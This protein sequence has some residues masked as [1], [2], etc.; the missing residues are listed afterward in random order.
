MDCSLTWYGASEM[1]VYWPP[2][3]LSFSRPL[4]SSQQKKMKPLKHSQSSPLDNHTHLTELDN[5]KSQPIP[6]RALTNIETARA[7]D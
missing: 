6:K 2:T 3:I 1:G 5:E 7:G 4:L